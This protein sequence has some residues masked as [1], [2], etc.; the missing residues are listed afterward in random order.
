VNGH[1]DWGKFEPVFLPPYSPDLNLIERPW[2]LL[3]A[4]WFCDRIAKDREALMAR[5]DLALQWVIAR[6]E[7]NQKTCAIKKE[8]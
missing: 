5:L 2:R 4:E 7:G 8:L 3:K 1:L 6:V